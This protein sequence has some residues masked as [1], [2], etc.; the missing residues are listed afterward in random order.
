ML[1]SVSLKFWLDVMLRGNRH[2]MMFLRHGSFQLRG[3]HL[4]FGAPQIGI[5][6]FTGFHPKSYSTSASQVKVLEMLI[7]QIGLQENK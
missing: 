3:A 1:L 6:I 4:E 2:V 7:L 5:K